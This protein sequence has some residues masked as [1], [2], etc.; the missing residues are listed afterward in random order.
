MK[1]H[2]S[3]QRR[4]GNS[5]S[6][7]L[8]ALRAL[9]QDQAAQEDRR[10]P[11]KKFALALLSVFEPGDHPLRQ[12][13]LESGLPILPGRG[14]AP[15]RRQAAGD[16]QLQV[17]G[18][19]RN[20]NYRDQ[21]G[22][23]ALPPPGFTEI[24]SSYVPAP[25]PSALRRSHRRTPGTRAEATTTN[26]I[27]ARFRSHSCRRRALTLH[28]LHHLPH[29]RDM[30]GS[31]ALAPRYEALRGFFQVREEQRICEP[32]ANRCNDR[33]DALPD[34]KKFA[35]GLKEEVFV[36]EPVVEQCASVFP[37]TEHHH[38]QRAIFRAGRREAHEVLEVLHEVVLEE[39]VAPLAQPS[40]AP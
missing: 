3:H 36:K 2:A 40:L 22:T 25:Q 15:R 1:G 13:L 34:P 32:L 28:L 4:R 14:Q 35:A 23:E 7:A 11:G 17:Y 24:F 6:R 39:R 38:A 37:I 9:G 19:G 26:R 12:V 8:P 16:A 30:T 5:G 10:G 21:P 27:A 31:A 29:G 18:H 33:L 20:G